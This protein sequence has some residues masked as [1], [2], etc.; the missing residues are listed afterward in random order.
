M[1]LSLVS[2][3]PWIVVAAVL[4]ATGTLTLLRRQR[5]EHPATDAAPSPV[6]E[7]P[8]VDERTMRRSYAL[9]ALGEA[10]LILDRDARI[11]DCN[12]SALALFDRHRSAIEDQFGSALRR[13]EGMDQSDPHRV[14]S[15]RAVWLGEAWARQP[16]GGVKLCLARVIAVRDRQAR[17]TGFVESFRDVTAERALSEEFRDL[18]YGVRAFDSVSGSPNETV[19]AIRADIRVLTEAFRDLDLVVRQYERLLPSLGADDP[20]TESIAGV[21]HEARAAV[22]SVGVAALLEEIPRSLARLRGHLQ[23]VVEELGVGEEPPN[24]PPPLPTAE[25]AVLG[26]GP[27]RARV[28][29]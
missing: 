14:A 28:E 11:R 21:A 22:A 9:D 3:L 23:E 29:R 5:R 1:N 26:N 13:F 25:R 7:E 16:D 4:L 10:V 8:L 20:L 15:E 6:S 19:R 17:L 2:L 12:S 27:S 24:D 18:L